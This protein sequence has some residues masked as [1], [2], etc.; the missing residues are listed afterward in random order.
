MFPAS[1]P[2]G[3]DPAS[4]VWQTPPVV[5][6][7]KHSAKFPAFISREELLTSQL[8]IYSSRGREKKGFFYQGPIPFRLADRALLDPAAHWP[9]PEEKG[10]FKS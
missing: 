5:T 8:S 6:G 9:Q 10:T 3:V 7:F 1:R 2:T 4:A